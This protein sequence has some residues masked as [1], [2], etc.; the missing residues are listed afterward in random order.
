MIQQINND[1]SSLFNNGNINKNLFEK[2]YIKEDEK[3]SNGILKIMPKIHKNEFGIRPIISCL[4]HVTSKICKAIEIMLNPFIKNVKHI[5]KDSQ[6][7]LQ[8]LENFSYNGNMNL[9]SCDFESLYTKIDSLQAINTISLFV[10]FKTNILIKHKIDFQAFK[11]FLTIIFTCNNFK[12]K[13]FYYLQCI[14]IPMGCICGPSIANMY[15]YILEISWL[16]L[17]PDLIYYRFIDDIFIASKLDLDL[18]NFRL[19]FLY[20]KLNIVKDNEVVFLD[21]KITFSNILEKFQFDLYIKPTNTFGY[22][23]PISNHP[24]HIFKNIPCSLIKRIRRICSSYNNYLFHTRNLLIQLLKRGYNI[25]L[26]NGLIR[27][28]GEI[29]RKDLLPYKSEYIK[30]KNNLKFFLTYDSKIK[31]IKKVLYNNFYKFSQ[32]NIFINNKNLMLIYQINKNFGSVLIDQLK[33]DKKLK[34][35]YK[36]CNSF[37]CNI[38]KFSLNF[39]FIKNSNI[40]FPILSNSSCD[41][42]GCIYCII[43]L[44]CY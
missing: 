1:L 37:N 24:E 8:E 43:C 31:F 2:L 20:L 36:K 4:S 11:T 30:N 25:N 15:I 21:L 18:E 13:N 14:G 35:S 38:C 9:Y 26:I 19:I 22:L 23:L 32:E 17:N 28:I 27:S 16:N 34:F 39:H 6:Q 44:K 42:I 40:C 12:Y 7:L 33:T 3:V 5:L 29:K 41:S 10:N